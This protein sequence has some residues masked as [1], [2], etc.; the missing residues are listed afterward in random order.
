MCDSNGRDEMEMNAEGVRCR[1]SKL[2]IKSCK[3]VTATRQGD[4]CRSQF[5]SIA[6]QWKRM[7]DK[8]SNG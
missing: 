7:F 4:G 1:S 8:L 2:P 6:K 3:N 5:S